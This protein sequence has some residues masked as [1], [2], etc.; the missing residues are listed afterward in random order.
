[1]WKGSVLVYR[2]LLR[3]RLDY[4]QEKGTIYDNKGKEIYSTKTKLRYKLFS[5]KDLGEKAEAWS[6]GFETLFQNYFSNVPLRTEKSKYRGKGLA[7][8]WIRV[9]SLFKSKFKSMRLGRLHWTCIKHAYFLV[10]SVNSFVH[11][12]LMRSSFFIFVGIERRKICKTGHES[13]I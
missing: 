4:K 5:W 1:M 13:N 9:L 12:P 3:T 7:G 8:V 6:T 2:G 11:N 10:K